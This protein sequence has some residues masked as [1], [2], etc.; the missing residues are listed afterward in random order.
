MST[1]WISWSNL[2]PLSRCLRLRIWIHRSS[3]HLLMKR[4]LWK[5]NT[6][7]L[8]KHILGVICWWISLAW[9]LNYHLG[10]FNW[11]HHSRIITLLYI[12]W[13]F[14]GIWMLRIVRNIF[15]IPWRKLNIRILLS[16]LCILLELCWRWEYIIIC[17]RFPLMVISYST[18]HIYQIHRCTWL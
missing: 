5:F 12:S 16:S 9:S 4:C 7:C 15:W 8:I 6:I 10:L 14:W 11:G 13:T 18:F 1:A 17:R 3:W 2:R